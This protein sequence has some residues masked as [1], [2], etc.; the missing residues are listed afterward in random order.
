M[1][2]RPRAGLLGKAAVQAYTPPRTTVHLAP[3]S[4]RSTAFARLRRSPYSRSG[5]AD[6]PRH[7]RLAIRES[8]SVAHRLRVRPNAVRTRVRKIADF[9]HILAAAIRSAGF[10]RSSVRSVGVSRFTSAVTAPDASIW[11]KAGGQMI[12][13]AS[14]WVLA[15]LLG[16]ATAY[17][18]QGTTEVRGRVVDPQGA[19][20][21][22]V[23]VTVRNQDTGMFRETVSGTDGTSSS[24]ASCP[25][26]TRSAPSCRASRS[27]CA[28]DVELEIGKTATHRRAARGRRALA[29]P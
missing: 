1:R 27:S 3:V 16:V 6:S 17:A 5:S 22:G 21:P 8:S 10:R 23:T 19:M 26:D 11:M 28:S 12:R 24:A 9:P 18:Q 29:K 4:Q 20:L 2:A 15:L 25:G 7:R 14:A 13:Q